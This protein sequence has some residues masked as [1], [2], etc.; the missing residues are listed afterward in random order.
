MNLRTIDSL[1]KPDKV[2]VL[3]FQTNFES[4]DLAIGFG[5]PLGTFLFMVISNMPLMVTVPS[6][7]F[8]GTISLSLMFA[9]PGYLNVGEFLSTIRYHIKHRGVVD[10]S[11]KAAVADDVE[12][13][14]LREFKTDETTR[15]MTNIRRFYPEAHILE[16]TDG[17]YVGALRIEP[18]NRDFDDSE[19]FARVANTIKEQ[20]NKNIDFEFQFYVT[21][22]PFPIE[23]YVSKLEERLEDEDIQ[24][25]PIME[26][27]LQEKVQRR[28]E[29]L[30]E[31][32]TELPHYYLV[33]SVGPRSIEMEK[34]GT[35]SPIERMVDIPV[36]GLFF[37]MM[38]NIRSDV[39]D[40]QREVRMIKKV[41]QRLSR[42]DASI[43]QPNSEFES[44][45]VSVAEWSEIVHSFW[46][47]NDGV[48]PE[49]RQ[50]SAVASVTDI[51]EVSQRL[52]GNGKP[53]DEDVGVDEGP[54]VEASDVS[55]N[56]Q[57]TDE[58]SKS[59]FDPIDGGTDVEDNSGPATDND[60]MFEEITS[61]ESQDN[62]SMEE[63]E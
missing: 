32:G 19:D 14:I 63:D 10:N 20:L 2:T 51:P 17:H 40:H 15:E 45:P 44:H 9:A 62:P 43:V 12:G 5:L 23:D 13:G 53:A 58:V 47:G 50:Q 27:I 33:A 38:T 25:K 56:S 48:G 60:T 28:P 30:K 57:E 37:E 3:G 7:V 16:R 31:R 34:S 52:S 24:S 1:R 4:K 36:L 49:I 41:R 61:S 35:T 18:P 39:E 11:V 59:D 55:Q 54:V 42:L 6:V 8:V 22:R 21:T 29:D 46:T 26:A